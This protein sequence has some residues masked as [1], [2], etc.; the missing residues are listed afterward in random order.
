MNRRSRRQAAPEDGE[1]DADQL[2]AHTDDQ[3]EA[4]VHEGERRQVARDPLA[5]LLH[6]PGR[7]ADL[8]VAEEAD[9]PVAQLFSAHQHE[10]HEDQDEAADAE[11]FE[12]RADG[13]AELILD[14]RPADDLHLLDPRLPLLRSL[15]L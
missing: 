8:A 6:R 11:E 3:P 4:R 2:Q 14:R 9:D 1:G 5:D 10:Q 13:R 7:Q 12:V 15:E